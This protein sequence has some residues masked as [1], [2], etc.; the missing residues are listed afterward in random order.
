[1]QLYAVVLMLI[2]FAGRPAFITQLLYVGLL[3]SGN[4]CMIT[5]GHNIGRVGQIVHVEKHPGS[6][7]IVHVKDSLGHNFATR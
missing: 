7:H 3:L 6:F 1:M 5:G 2:G 4:M